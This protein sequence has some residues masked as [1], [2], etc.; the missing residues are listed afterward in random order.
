MDQSLARIR[1][2]V[3]VR[4]AVSY[5]AAGAIVALQVRQRNC[6][7]GP[8]PPSRWLWVGGTWPMWLGVMVCERIKK[9]CARIR[10]V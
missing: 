8:W 5:V 7:S 1:S 9:D 10:G 2:E 4:L 6:M 3:M